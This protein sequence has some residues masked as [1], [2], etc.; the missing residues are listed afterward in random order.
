MAKVAFA[1]SSV[2]MAPFVFK[3]AMMIGSS[4]TS[5]TASSLSSI[6]MLTDVSSPSMLTRITPASPSYVMEASVLATAVGPA[7]NATS[8]PLRART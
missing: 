6:S 1:S 8:R 2:L 5:F 7:S 3:W 4:F